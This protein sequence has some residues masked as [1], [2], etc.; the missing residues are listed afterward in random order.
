M[1]EKKKTTTILIGVDIRDH[2]KKMGGKGE[3]YNSILKRLL[4]QKH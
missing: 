4:E 1:P 3:T 2:L